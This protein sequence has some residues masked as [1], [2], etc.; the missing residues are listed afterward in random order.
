MNKIQP[1]IPVERLTLQALELIIASRGWSKHSSKSLKKSMF[2]I[3]IFAL[4]DE[5]IAPYS[6]SYPKLL[7]EVSDLAKKRIQSPSEDI[8]DLSSFLANCAFEFF[9]QLEEFA[10]QEGQ[11]GEKNLS[12]ENEHPASVNG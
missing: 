11:H 3:F 10:S 7:Q 1:T 6:S 12:T 5:E 8:R 4:N 2:D 9:S